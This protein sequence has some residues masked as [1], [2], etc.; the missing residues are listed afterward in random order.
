[1]RFGVL[2]VRVRG[3]AIVDV[4]CHHAKEYIV[5]P[6]QSADSNF[7]AIESRTT[8]FCAVR[9]DPPTL[10]VDLADFSFAATEG[11]NVTWSGQSSPFTHVPFGV[12]GDCRTGGARSAANV[13]LRGTPFAVADAMVWVPAPNTTN[14]QI[15]GA[16]VRAGF[17]GQVV[18]I[19][20]GGLCG[21]IAPGHVYDLPGGAAICS[22]YQWQLQL[23]IA[24]PPPTPS[25]PPLPA[26][27]VPPRN[28]ETPFQCSNRDR[29]LPPPPLCP[30]PPTPPSSLPFPGLTA[31]TMHSCPRVPAADMRTTPY[32]SN[33][34]NVSV[35]C[36]AAGIANGLALIRVRGGNVVQLLCA[37]GREYLILPN[38]IGFSNYGQLQTIF[39]FFCAIRIDPRTLLVD[40]GDLTFSS[41]EGEVSS[42]NGYDRVGF[43]VA[44]DC[45]DNAVGRAKI[46]LTSTPFVIDESATW[47]IAGYFPSG[48]ATVQ[49]GRK[50]VDIWGDGHCGY[51]VPG[52][53]D[54][55]LTND[56]SGYQWTLPLRVGNGTDGITLPSCAVPQRDN[57]TTGCFTTRLSELPPIAVCPTPAPTPAPPTPPP[58]PSP[59]TT[60]PVPT[61][62]AS[63]RNC[64]EIAECGAC[65][66]ATTV[67]GWCAHNRT[68]GAGYCQSRS[69]TACTPFYTL[70]TASC[71]V[72]TTAAPLTTT[73]ATT[74]T[75]TTVAGQTTLSTTPVLSTTTIAGQTTAATPLP[76]TTTTV[77]QSTTAMP[78]VGAACES[79]DACAT[80][81][82]SAIAT[83]G[84]AWCN[85]NTVGFP[86]YCRSSNSTALCSV[87]FPVLSAVTC[88]VPTTPA[89]TLTLTLP[90][91]SLTSTSAE[92]SVSDTTSLA[93]SSTSASTESSSESL[94]STNVS[95]TTSTL[96]ENATD[97]INA[98]T[99]LTS[100]GWF[101]GAIVGGAVLL[102]LI[103]LLVV[104]LVVR[105]RRRR[106]N[107][108]DHAS[109]GTRELESQWNNDSASSSTTKAPQIANPLSSSSSSESPR[110]GNGIYTAAPIVDESA[111]ALNTGVYGASPVVNT[112]DDSSVYTAPPV[113]GFG[114]KGSD[115]GSTYSAPP[116][117]P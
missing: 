99:P 30:T 44:G 42:W 43:G 114:R 17:N 69:L 20:A 47:K 15:T 55:G 77:P 50:I 88:P 81:L 16:T 94:A 3:G 73:V 23:K 106:N 79:Y 36:V 76:T 86:G 111:V 92:P 11:A 24:A 25:P 63:T 19:T 54:W 28:T 37:G 96:S 22:A 93:P 6:A 39:T 65:I 113:S 52:P 32:P 71:P 102:C 66:G 45:N 87:N 8:R 109:T 57:F 21:W 61:T 89:T 110:S 38:A 83:T 31:A 117:V 1:M 60:I 98:E 18:D 51:N 14:L 48:A 103:V 75:T 35:S 26:C 84:C 13:D 5:L 67:C 70:A 64:S 68:D 4:L 108:D 112:E 49:S 116:I 91:V 104:G 78:V 2:R 27:D 7:A 101:I 85:R 72:A 97:M 33:T 34:P 9:F 107:G 82:N 40:T 105:S 56:C 29:T 90:Q 80:C 10:L 12:A 46:D 41:T 59:S 74:T 100:E 115:G 58:T 95:S 53:N 62:V